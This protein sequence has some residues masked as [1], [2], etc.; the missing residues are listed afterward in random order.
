MSVAEQTGLSLILSE[1]PE[2]RFVA[3]RLSYLDDHYVVS[4]VD[5]LTTVCMMNS[6]MV[7]NT[8]QKYLYSF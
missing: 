2:D 1:K 7:I 6:F 5:Q 4:H 8:V 3:L